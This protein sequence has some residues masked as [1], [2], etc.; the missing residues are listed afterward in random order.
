VPSMRPRTA[1]AVWLTGWLMAKGRS[2]P[3]IDRTGTKHDDAKVSGKMIGK[4]IAWAASAFGAASPTKA[5]PHER[6]YAKIN[7]KRLA[8]MYSMNPP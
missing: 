3:G 4:T 2:Q 5:K 6:Q 1:V 8:W 7:I